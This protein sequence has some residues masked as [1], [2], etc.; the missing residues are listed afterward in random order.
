VTLVTR[1]FILI[2]FTLLLVAG[3]EVIN[4]LNLRQNR[5]EE[6]R[7]DTVQLARIAELDMVRILD[8]THQLLA[9]LAK[10]PT[11]HGW[12]ERACSVLEVTASSDFEYDHITAVDRNGTIQCSSSGAAR[13][14]APMAEPELLDRIV[15]TAGFAVGSY[16]LGLVS[17]NEVIRVG[18]PVV[19]DAGTVIGAVYAGIN[20]TWLNTA[21]SQWQ[22]G[23]TA[24]IDI[25][26]RNGTVIARHPDP[27]GV[28]QPISDSL[29]PFL[30]AADTGAA[31]VK[32]VEGVVR[33]YGYVPVNAGPSD[34]LAVFV[35]RDRM[36]IFA[37]INHSIW[38]NA[39]VV[40]MALLLSGILAVIYIRRLLARPFHS[41]LTVAGRWRDG[42]WSVRT[43]A[44]SGIPE[45]DGLSLAFDGMAAEVSARDRTLRQ[46]RDFTT[47]LI[48]SL[49]GV[50]VLIDEQG[51]YVRWNANLSALTG[52]P[53]AQLRGFDAFRF[54]VERDRGLART[55]L[56]EAFTQGVAHFEG[57]VIAERG[58]RTIQFSGR[59][60]VSEGQPYVL[61]VGTDMTEEREAEVRL[62][63]SEERFRAVSEAAQDAIIMADQNGKVVYWNRAAERT[64]GYTVDEAIGRNVHEWLAPQQFREKA[65]AGMRDFAATG[66]GYAL[67]KTL[68]LAA[69]RKDGIEIPIE[70]SLASMLLGA[71]WHAVA[72][73]RDITERKR[74]EV[75]I[76]RMARHDILTGLANRGV[77]VEALEATIALA[78]RT[79][80]EFA[81]LYMDLDHFKDV[82]DTLGHPVGD[83]LL[84]SVAER[85]KAAVRETDTVA[86]FGGDEFA[87]IAT[88]LVE[89]A[90]A[91]ILADNVL[92]AVS[93]PIS[94]Q[95]MELRSGASVGIAVYG[96]D[97]GDAET[98]LSHADVA[99]Y[100]AKSEGRGTYRFFTDAMD[101]EVRTRV[102]VGAELRN[103]IVAG[104]L[105]LVYQPQVDIDTGRIVGLEALVRWRH[106]T[107]GVVSPDQFIPVAERSGLIVALGRWVMRE[108]CRQMK[109]WLDAE[110]APPLIAVNLSA[111]Q[112]KRPLELEKDIE[113][114]LVETG[115]P[116]QRVEFELTESALM[117]ASRQ[118]GDVLLRLRRAG[119]R[120]AIDDF[121]TGYSSLDYLR[122]F[123][124][125]RIKIA[126]QF[127][128]DLTGA[129]GNAA[130][131]QAAI[132][133]AHALKLDVVVEGVETAE[134]LKLVKS[135]GCHE[136][137]GYYFSKP[138]RAEESTVL[139]RKGKIVPLHAAVI[140]EAA[141]G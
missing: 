6:V 99:L 92:T 110:I 39:A 50:F 101:A 40:L 117:D 26:D 140:I 113:A 96:A 114:I 2:A 72:I 107:R 73:L 58:E 61:V 17:G 115:V 112:F 64:L 46:E 34:G 78:R 68:E 126:Q 97:S 86:R 23:E 54:F 8:G 122:R 80:R 18:Y 57:A 87:L 16:G 100:R 139:L 70:I 79:G 88:N 137:Q 11:G 136:V 60:I 5:L 12:D 49:P 43:G 130:I 63:A 123:P 98:L 21:I 19:D 44:A 24:S 20:I 56:S 65:D 131:L 77:F 95:G 13:I 125:D 38:L 52:I 9:T 124:V 42:D 84:Q 106:P 22:L 127:M 7:S 91:A 74:I 62:R 35:G 111:L 69:I 118:H 36:Q 41:L 45:F 31:E 121:G 53:D 82:N 128:T 30:S 108:A 119:F 1:I 67:G 103:A 135:W 105:F 29:R 133:L 76:T 138:I 3:G 37:D 102:M 14:S 32:G 71:E 104:Q 25:T 129:S 66:R 109:E 4:G 59:R 83:L 47:A 55:R 94:I 33:L 27:R 89:P 81:V 85:L 93:E 134:Q 141:T 15:A 48:D 120:I 51:R 28:G 10:L 132:A 116:P 90:D 75:E